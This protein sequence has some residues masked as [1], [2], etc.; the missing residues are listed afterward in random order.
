MLVDRRTQ[1]ARHEALPALFGFCTGGTELRPILYDRWT[2]MH[3][4]LFVT[5]DTKAD[6]VVRGEFLLSRPDLDFAACA[7][8]LAR[9]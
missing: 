2:K 7:F 9:A 5:G 3:V 1:E 4:R 6:E 8:D